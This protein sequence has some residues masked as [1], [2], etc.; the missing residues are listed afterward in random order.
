LGLLGLIISIPLLLLGAHGLYGYFQRLDFLGAIFS[1]STGRLFFAIPVPPPFSDLVTW[2][3]LRGFQSFIIPAIFL[4]VGVAIFNWS[5]KQGIS[6]E[7]PRSS[8]KNYTNRY[9]SNSSGYNSSH[10]RSNVPDVFNFK[11][12]TN[13]YRIA[14]RLLLN[15]SIVGGT[16]AL[17]WGGN[18][19]F[20]HRTDPMTGSISLI[21]GIG[22]WIIIV[23]YTHTQYSNI[24]PSFKITTMT[25]IL[26]VLVMTFA[27]V[28]P[29]STYKDNLFEKG[30][31][32]FN[33]LSNK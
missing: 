7:L 8:H 9:N 30:S 13:A 31:E 15:L 12:R 21:A 23:W 27:G 25:I 33:R 32:I 1:G 3:T 5:I 28:E 6:I 20:S 18:E 22:L 4:L 17:I 14:L 11:P 26:V 24:Q 16:F 19:V 10:G 2:M 29:L